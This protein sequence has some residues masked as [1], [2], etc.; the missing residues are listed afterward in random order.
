MAQELK[1][2]R[3]KVV[4]TF[5]MINAIYIVVVF[6]LQNNKEILHF[7][8]P[9]GVQTNITFNAEEMEVNTILRQQ[10]MEGNDARGNITLG[11]R[12][13]MYVLYSR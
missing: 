9:L 3:N 8:W 11:G 2:L 4:F 10:T 5:S 7:N 6:L 1:E 13:S 12:W